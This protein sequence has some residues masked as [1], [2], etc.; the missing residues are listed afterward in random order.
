MH[1][2]MY[3]FKIV[4]FNLKE[5]IEHIGNTMELQRTKKM[6]LYGQVSISSI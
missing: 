3:A 6:L 1:T 2:C 4:A 5:N